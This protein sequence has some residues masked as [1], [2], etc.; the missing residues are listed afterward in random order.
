MLAS[1]AQRACGIRA[2]LPSSGHTEHYVGHKCHLF[3][4]TQGAHTEGVQT[5]LRFNHYL[6]S[7]VTRNRKNY[8]TNSFLLVKHIK[9]LILERNNKSCFAT[10][11]CHCFNKFKNIYNYFF[12]FY[13][14]YADNIQINII[15][16]PEIR[17]YY[18]GTIV[19]RYIYIFL[20]NTY[21]YKTL[22]ETLIT[23]CCPVYKKRT[24]LA[25]VM[26]TW[27]YFDYP[28]T[29]WASRWRGARAGSGLNPMLLEYECLGIAVIFP[30]V[31]ER[32]D[33][34]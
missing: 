27:P 7:W 2:K 16:F 28:G 17:G 10:V 25:Q 4:R 12:Y 33:T 20:K 32:I 22:L 18:F 3:H 21:V 1:Q 13:C 30:V 5:R 29:V 8:F 19:I 26:V 11:K 15:Y 23:L 31:D 9:A 6:G 14:Q 34:Q 24:R